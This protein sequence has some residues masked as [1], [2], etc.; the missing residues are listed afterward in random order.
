MQEYLQ[1]RGH[2]L[3]VYEVVDT[4]G[5]AHQQTF[6]IKCYLSSLDIEFFA[7]GMNRKEAE[8]TTASLALDYLI[9]KKQK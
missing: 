9:S 5:Q 6:D 7:S 1:K 8:Q 3:P 2:E 4:Q